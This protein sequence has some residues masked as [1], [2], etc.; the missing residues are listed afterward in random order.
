MNPNN[1]AASNSDE[2]ESEHLEESE[3]DGNEAEAE[4]GD[5][6]DLFNENFLEDY[7]A[8]PELD[9]Y[10]EEGMELADITENLS[11]EDAAEARRR[12]EAEMDARDRV[13]HQRNI[14]GR[15]R[16]RSSSL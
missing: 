13:Q 3:R 2:V 14:Y 16:I 5:G 7:R 4:A 9:R 11:L 8:I 1:D 10:E 15:Y 6:D 12:A